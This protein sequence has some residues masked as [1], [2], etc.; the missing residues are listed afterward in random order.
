[1]KVIIGITI[2]LLILIPV[3]VVL[4]GQGENKVQ[5]GATFYLR[6]LVIKGNATYYDAFRLINGLKEGKDIPGATF[7]E[8]K[9]KLA[10][11]KIIPSSWNNVKEKD[12]IN[13]ADFAYMLVK[14]LNIKGGLTLRLFGLTPRYALREC[15][16]RRLI[17][18]GFP[19][20]LISGG[21]L[22]SIL[23]RAEKY[24]EKEKGE[25]N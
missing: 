7:D 10:A 18:D 25:N 23:I 8:L 5:Q 2:I 6:G 11:G 13:R 14:T 17:P 9:N 20:Q 22:L 24:Q 4:N 21:E 15:V 3:T 16:M 19:N 12:F 1:M